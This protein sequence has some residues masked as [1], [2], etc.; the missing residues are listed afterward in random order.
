MP[1]LFNADEVFA[2][3][4]RIEKNGAAFYRKV[5]AQQAGDAARVDY[6]S[7]LAAMEDEHQQTFEAMRRELS[8]AEAPAQ[9][10]DLY[11]EG[12]LFLAAIAD[13]YPLEGAPSVAES[14]T[15]DETMEQILKIA[16]GLEKKSILFYLGMKDVV[17]EDRGRDKLDAIIG[18]E[19]AHVVG[20]TAELKKLAAA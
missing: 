4:I 10:T 20:L 9:S 8:A 3:A 7:K 17:P 1:V 11:N 6:L 14:L 5:A 13:G 12:Q 2:I 18:E 19:K 15:G 16:I